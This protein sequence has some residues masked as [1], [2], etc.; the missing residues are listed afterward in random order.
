MKA[1]QNVSILVA[2]LVAICLVITGGAQAAQ[3]KMI[4]Q[5]PKMKMTTPI[6]EN[7]TTPDKVKTSIGTLEFFDGVPIG[8]TKDMVY[9]FVDRGRAVEAFINMTPAASL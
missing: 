6:P 3:T 2:V 8:N 5:K 9:D 1:K 4:T 7:L